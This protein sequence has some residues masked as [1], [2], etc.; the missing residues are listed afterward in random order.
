MLVKIQNQK[1]NFYVLYN[2]L[3]YSVGVLI[4]RRNMPMKET[5]ESIIRKYTAM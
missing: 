3:K 4:V 5:L 2:T 1:H